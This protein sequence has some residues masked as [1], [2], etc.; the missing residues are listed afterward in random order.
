MAKRDDILAG[1]ALLNGYHQHDAS[2]LRVALTDL[3]DEE[4]VAHF[5]QI[6]L[7]LLTL[8]AKETGM[9][10]ERELQKLAATAT[11]LDD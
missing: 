4:T 6:A 3:N 7:L 5:A 10:E 11:D 2:S 9:T 8:L 1:I